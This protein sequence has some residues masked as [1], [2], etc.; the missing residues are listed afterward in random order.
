M[1]SRY[2]PAIANRPFLANDTI[3][4]IAVE[5]VENPPRNPVTN[6]RYVDC[7]TAMDAYAAAATPAQNVAITLITNVD[8]GNARSH[9]RWIEVFNTKRA[10]A[11]NPPHRHTSRTII[12]APPR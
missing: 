3:S 8:S 6:S 9:Q 7:S 12:P 2:Q 10:T 1:A 4:L 11:P 5:N